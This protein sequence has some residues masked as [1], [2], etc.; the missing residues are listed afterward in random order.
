MEIDAHIVP[1]TTP[2][3]FLQRVRNVLPEYA[4]AELAERANP[5]LQPYQIDEDRFEEILETVKSTEGVEDYETGYG[6]SVADENVLAQK[7]PILVMGPKGEN[8]HRP[9]EWVDLDSL[10]I[11]T[12]IFQNIIDTR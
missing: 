8:L 4:E 11:L 1:P 5:Y 10:E 12:Q 3:S 9:D 6:L 2:E 7:A